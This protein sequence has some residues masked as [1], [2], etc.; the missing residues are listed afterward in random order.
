[1][2]NAET[3]GFDIMDIIIALA[4]AGGI[5]LIGIMLGLSL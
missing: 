1:M 3:P 2:M 5:A 4:I